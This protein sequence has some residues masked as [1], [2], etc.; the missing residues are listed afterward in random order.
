M[1]ARCAVFEARQG[2]RAS[3]LR[4][5]AAAPGRFVRRTQGPLSLRCAPF[6][7]IT[8]PSQTAHG[9]TQHVCTVC[10]CGK[11][12]WQRARRNRRRS[13][14]TPTCSRS[15]LSLR[16]SNVICRRSIAR[17]A[18]AFCRACAAL[19]RLS[20]LQ[21]VAALACSVCCIVVELYAT[22]RRYASTPA[23]LMCM[24]YLT[25]A[26]CRAIY[27]FASH[28]AD[29]RLAP[30]FWTQWEAF[31]GRHGNANTWREMTRIHRCAVHCCSSTLV[32]PPPMKASYIV[33]VSA[34]SQC[35]SL[36]EAFQCTRRSVAA[37]F[38]SVHFNTT[39]VEASVP[40]ATG[41]ADVDP[42]DP[43]AALEAQVANA[44][45]RSCPLRSLRMPTLY[46]R[47]GLHDTSACEHVC[48]GSKPAWIARATKY[49][50]RVCDKRAGVCAGGEGVGG[51]VSAGVQGGSAAAAAEAVASA[52][53]NPEELDI[54]DDDDDE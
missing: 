41:G 19:F 28:L 42:S 34:A 54:G 9:S 15:R 10:R 30:H 39:N 22:M 45:A 51:F 49:C 36:T 44:G 13:C 35:A 24:Q 37:S 38:S 26:W 5:Y 40:V 52:P 20:L 47:A 14:Q 23:W 50:T 2:Q 53:A 3:S 29:D 21:L 18:L 6:L 17:G 25:H 1:I 46:G 31:E 27:T 12:T 43:M 48:L 16:R 7:C 4:V 33:I 32:L 8:A 11:C